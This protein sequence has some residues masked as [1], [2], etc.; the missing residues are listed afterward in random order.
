VLLACGGVEPDAD[1]SGGSSSTGAPENLEPHATFVAKVD[2]IG[3]CGTEGATVVTFVARRIGCESETAPCTIKADPY[4][5]WSGTPSTCPSSQTALDM[6]V[7][8]PITGRYQIDAVTMTPSGFQSVCFGEGADVPT[9][10]TTTQVE[11]RAEIFVEQTAK[12]CPDPA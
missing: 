7:E 1:D 2:V 5:E 4:Q 10:V 8:V 11:A 12:P 6:Q 9:V 3:L